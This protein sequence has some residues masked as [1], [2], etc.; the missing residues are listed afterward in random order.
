M[1]YA[2][3]HH[4]R[5]A[6]KQA[7][8][9]LRKALLRK[10]LKDNPK[11]INFFGVTLF[12]QDKRAEAYKI[13]DR[14]VRILSD[15]IVY[16][17]YA[18]CCSDIGKH[19]RA[20][21]FYRKGLSIIEGAVKR[22]ILSNKIQ[23]YDYM[24]D[25]PPPSQILNDY[26]SVNK[27]LVVGVPPKESKGDMG[28]PPKIKIGYISSDFKAHVVSFYLKKIIELHNRDKFQV[29]CF[30]NNLMVDQVSASYLSIPDTDWFKI[31]EQKPETVATWIKDC[32]IDILIDLSGHTG[33]NRL[34]VFGLRPAPIQ[35]SYLGFPNTTGLKTIDYRLC[36]KYTDPI[37][38][39][40]YFSEKLVRMN[41]C[42]VC[43]DRGIPPPAVEYYPKD[44]I[45]FG[46]LN[47]KSK[48]NKHTYKAWSKIVNSVPNSR[49]VIKE[50]DPDLL[51]IAPSR[52]MVMSYM[53]TDEY[54]SFIKSQVD[55]CLD[56]FP[57][58][59]T[60]TTCDTLFCST[61]VITLSM[62]DRHVANVGCSILGHMNRGEL[63]AF[64]IEDYIKRAVDLANDSKRI[65]SYKQS[66][67]KDFSYIMNHTDFM[68]EYE[69][70]LEKLYKSKLL[71][72]V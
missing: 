23:N 40:Q 59:G 25:L 66:L 3:F 56:T 32:G 17:N 44:Y 43:Y 46:V 52:V 1:S 41:R 27:L 5:G 30:H 53:E 8:S 14:I 65:V 48:Y 61:P 64:H 62:T 12:Q 47:K 34:D 49:L 13:F 36:D 39:R 38:T 22:Q 71:T 54:L 45:L 9:I 37:D 20:N 10:T 69:S 26:E 57:Y 11:L 50:Y 15:P 18:F 29:F 72:K 51:K 55:I 70:T 67:Y 4:K 42:F 58:N 63:V 6:V 16:N 21:D 68:I 24:Y 35:I 31:A 60:T 33:G 19:K 2:I 7:E 28:V